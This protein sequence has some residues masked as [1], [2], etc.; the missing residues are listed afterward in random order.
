ML[1]I[2]WDALGL[3]CLSISCVGSLGWRKNVNQHEKCDAEGP[4]DTDNQG[5][6]C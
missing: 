2:N 6:F 5:F 4:K 3:E 1:G